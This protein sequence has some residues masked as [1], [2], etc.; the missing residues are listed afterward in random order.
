MWDVF[1][2]PKGETRSS[3]VL[4]GFWRLGAIA[5]MLILLGGALST[6]VGTY[7]AYE[8]STRSMV[9]SGG[10]AATLIGSLVVFLLIYGFGWGMAGFFRDA[11]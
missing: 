1:R 10:L 3:R 7:L 8:S 11:E 9:F 4:R 2:Q 5:M 6:L